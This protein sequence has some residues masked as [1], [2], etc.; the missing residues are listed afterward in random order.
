VA[1]AVDAREDEAVQARIAQRRPLLQR[2]LAAEGEPGLAAWRP[3]LLDTLQVLRTGR[4]AVQYRLAVGDEVLASEP[5]A[6]AAYLDPEG[7]TLYVSYE[8]Q[9]V[10]WP[11]IARELALAIKQERVAGG[12]A[13]AMREVL[14]APS[15]T[16]AGRMLDELGY[17]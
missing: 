14:A 10:P 16:E 2:V 6:V 11:A 7:N 5:E 17:P 15:A 9:H 12:L 3:Q 13:I 1:E 8:A 4:L